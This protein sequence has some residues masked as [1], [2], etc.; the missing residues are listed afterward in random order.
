MGDGAVWLIGGLDPS[1]GGGVLRDAA[2]V[3]AVA[4]QRP[5]HVVVTALTQQ[6]DGKKAVAG[7]MNADALRFQF[8]RAPKPAVIKVGLVPA[9]VASIVA[10][11][12]QGV[13]APRVVDP[14]L[15]ASIGG[16]MAANP[17]ALLPLMTGA[18]VTPNRKEY[19][20]LVGGAD[21]QGWLETHGA[22]GMLRKG[23]HDGEEQVSDTLWTPGGARVFS[24]PRIDGPDPRGTGCA[25]A[26]AIACGLA[27]GAEMQ[28]AAGKGIAWLDGVRAQA[29][30]VGGQVLLR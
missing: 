9:A 13:D 15:S 16:L 21:P 26:V 3:Q 7:P 25:L 18:L 11:A 24:R 19:D 23:G 4:P 8:R 20:T 2:T 22:V 5:V 14:V 30:T 6:G 29:R 12:L 28:A 17:E 27:E 10:E 1:G